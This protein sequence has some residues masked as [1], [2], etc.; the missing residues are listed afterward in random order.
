LGN[1]LALAAFLHRRESSL[2]DVLRAENFGGEKSSHADPRCDAGN[3]CS[4]NS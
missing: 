2:E 1:Y 4:G 3:A